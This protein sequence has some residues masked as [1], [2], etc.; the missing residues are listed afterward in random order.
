MGGK[1]VL[2]IGVDPHAVLQRLGQTVQIPEVFVQ[3]LPQRQAAAVVRA[4]LR[5]P[6]LHIDLEHL[7][8]QRHSD[9]RVAVDL[10][11]ED[12]RIG[13]HLYVQDLGLAAVSVCDV[14]QG[15]FRGHALHVP[16]RLLMLQILAAG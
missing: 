4:E 15:H 2:I 9:Q 5:W 16:F 10:R 14:G 1:E 6:C 7:A 11:A 3:S 12:H 13:A 8:V